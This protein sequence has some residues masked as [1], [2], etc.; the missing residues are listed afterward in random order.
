MSGSATA[1]GSEPK[2]T[3]AEHDNLRTYVKARFDDLDDKVD[4]LAEQ[5]ALFGQAMDLLLKHHGLD[6]DNDE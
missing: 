6:Q 1:N 4:N 5:M 2:A 3:K